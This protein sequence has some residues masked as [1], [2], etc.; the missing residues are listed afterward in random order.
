[1][2]TNIRAALTVIV[3]LVAAVVFY[4]ESAAESGGLKWIVVALAVFMVYGLWLYPET[5]RGDGGKPDGS[6]DRP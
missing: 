5:K 4:F 1:M 6:A 2:P 3:V